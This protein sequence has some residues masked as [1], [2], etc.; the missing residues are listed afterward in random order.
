MTDPERLLDV[1]EVAELLGVQVVHVYDLLRSGE[2]PGINVGRGS[3]RIRWRV[4]PSDLAEWQRQ[5]EVK[6]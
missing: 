6:P 1:D 5:R 4:R 2:L 3:Q